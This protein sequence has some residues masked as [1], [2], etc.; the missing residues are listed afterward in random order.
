MGSI[1]M[2]IENM[3]GTHLLAQLVDKLIKAEIHLRLHFVKEEL[4]P[5]TRSASQP[6]IKERRT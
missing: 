1:Q 3:S 5:G 2:G 6:V 4:F